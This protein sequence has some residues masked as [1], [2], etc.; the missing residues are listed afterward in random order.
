MAI[1]NGDG[2]F[3]ITKPWF[4]RGVLY[5]GVFVVRNLDSTLGMLASYA[6][7]TPRITIYSM[8]TIHAVTSSSI[9][10]LLGYTGS[11][12]S[13]YLQHYLHCII[14]HQPFSLPSF[15]LHPYL[16]NRLI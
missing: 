16:I 1:S 9:A 7:E 10:L 2:S 11:R 15:H 6:T 12:V 3:Q 13:S 14:P 8:S 4:Q 5:L